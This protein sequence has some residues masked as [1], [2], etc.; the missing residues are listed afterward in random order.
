MSRRHAKVAQRRPLQRH[1]R[2][3]ARQR[4]SRHDPVGSKESFGFLLTK[5]QND[6]MAKTAMHCS[7]STTLFQHELYELRR[8]RGVKHLV[9]TG[10]Y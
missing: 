10:V 4:W 2:I 6:E 5:R 7:V 1:D 3:G 8:Q 9:F